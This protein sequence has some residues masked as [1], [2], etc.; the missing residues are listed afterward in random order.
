M[1]WYENVLRPLLFRLSKDDAEVA[2]DLVLNL[3]ELFVRVP[4]LL[5]LLEWT[6]DVEDARLEQQLFGLAFRNPV[7]VAGG[8]FK[9]GKGL[10]AAQALGFGF[11]EM[12]TITPLPQPGFDRPRIHRLLDLEALIN[13]MGFPNEGIEGAERRLERMRPLAIP[14]GINV[15]R[16][17]NTSLAHAPD[18]YTGVVERL[19]PY[20]SLFVVNVSS[21]NTQGL[22]ALQARDE[23]VRVVRPVKAIVRFRA[24]KGKP[25]PV[26]LKISPD[27]THDELMDVIRVVADEQLDGIIATNTTISR[28][29]IDGHPKASLQ[30]GLSGPPLFPVALEKVRFITHETNG[31]IPVIGVG[32][33]NSFARA[34][35]MYEAGACAIEILT[36]FVYNGPSFPGELNDKTLRHMTRQELATL[37]DVR[38]FRGRDSTSPAA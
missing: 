21:P 14:I 12:G 13:R 2:H 3:L 35:E 24:G 9:T 36:G 11:V 23:L 7:G 8:L 18:D 16:G 10:P 38:R 31:H 20:A 28:E 30:G 19:H 26:L 17:K 29:L 27:L 15:G 37:D 5:K 25:K 4:F 1:R 34:R 33:I 22:R 6:Y 32:G